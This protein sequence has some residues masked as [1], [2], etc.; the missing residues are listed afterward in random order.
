MDGHKQ[1]T[2]TKDCFNVKIIYPIMSFKFLQMTPVRMIY[3]E[4]GVV[5]LEWS[6]AHPN[7]F[8]AWGTISC[9]VNFYNLQTGEVIPSLQLPALEK[10]ALISTV[11]CNP[12]RFV[13]TSLKLSSF[14]PLLLVH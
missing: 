7:L 9:C 4:A 6:L 3:V 13:P 11:R 12:H 8:G 10:P 14:L 2:D 1:E 5:G